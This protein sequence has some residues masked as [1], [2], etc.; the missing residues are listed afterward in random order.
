MLV[1]GEGNKPVVL[2]SLSFP[3]IWKDLKYVASC[4]ARELTALKSLFYPILHLH[5]FNSQNTWPLKISQ[6][7]MNKYKNFQWEILL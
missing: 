1:A 3:R 6:C 2:P 4:A 7:K 5:T